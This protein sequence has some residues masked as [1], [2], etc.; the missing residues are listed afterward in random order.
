MQNGYIGR[1]RGRQPRWVSDAVC[2]KT[3]TRSM[4]EAVW[5][6]P[7]PMLLTR[8][9]MVEAVWLKPPLVPAPDQ[10]SASNKHQLTLIWQL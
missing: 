4:V 5:L 2:S 8:L 6:K 9:H 7:L 3:P 1:I 10:P